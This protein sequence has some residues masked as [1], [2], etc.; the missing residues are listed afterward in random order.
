V[1]ESRWDLEY[2]AA[3]SNQWQMTNVKWKMENDPVATARGSDT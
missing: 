1:R 2:A 3:M